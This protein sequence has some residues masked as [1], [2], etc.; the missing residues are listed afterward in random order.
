MGNEQIMDEYFSF[1]GREK[2]LDFRDVVEEEI[3]IYSHRLY[4]WRGEGRVNDNLSESTVQLTM[5]MVI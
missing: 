3:V 1:W 4:V 5:K 2:K